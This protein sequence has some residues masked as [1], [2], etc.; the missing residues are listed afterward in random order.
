MNTHYGLIVG[1][2]PSDVQMIAGGSF[3]SCEA[4]LAEWIEAHPLEDGQEIEVVARTGAMLQF[5]LENPLTGVEEIAAPLDLDPLV[6]E[7]TG[8]SF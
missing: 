5:I 8:E 3:E 1:P 2:T 6:Y 4:A 7:Y